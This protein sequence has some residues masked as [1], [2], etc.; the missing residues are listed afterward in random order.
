MFALSGLGVRL[1][2][3]WVIGF[4]RNG[5][6]IRPEYA[7]RLDEHASER[8][9]RALS[10]G[11]YG[12][13]WELAR[14][15][16]LRP[17]VK[18]YGG[19][20]EPQGCGGAGFTVT[21]RGREWLREAVPYDY[22]PTEPG[23]FAKILANFVPRFGPGFAERSQE[24]IRCYGALA[25]VACCAMCGAAAESILLAVAIAATGNAEKVLTSYESAGGRG[26]V[27]NLVVGKRPKAVQDEF[28]ADLN[29]LK[30]WRDAAAHGQK[31]GITESEAY[32]SLALL[33]RFAQFVNDRWDELTAG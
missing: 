27:E 26:R 15:G 7:L 14:R 25:Y 6:S 28:R 33:L 19:Q 4:A 12:A 24:A 21:L 2:P 30:Y 22:V 16:I 1:G 17:G 29:L 32:T 5:R 20:V 23:R 31:S 13:A 11:L 18:E 10:P 3:E 9:L 8:E